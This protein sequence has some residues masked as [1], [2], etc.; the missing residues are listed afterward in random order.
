MIALGVTGS[1]AAYKAADLCRSFTKIGARVTVLMT[2]AAHEFIGSATMR[3]L[4]GRQVVTDLFAEGFPHIDIGKEAD[5]FVIAPATANT[6]AKLAAGVADCPITTTAAAAACPI[7]VC[8]AMN[9]T[10]WLSTANL[11]NIETLKALG[12]EII[13]PE[14]GDLA[15]G[16]EGWGRL[17]GLERIERAVVNRLASLRQLQGKKVMVTAGPT[18]EFLDPVRFIS[19]PSSGKT[20]YFVAEELA[21]RGADVVLVSGPTALSASKG[22]ELVSVATALDMDEQCRER[23]ADVDAVV[24]TAAVSDHR[25]ASVSSAKIEKSEFPTML[26]FE[27][28]PDILA[29]LGRTKRDQVLIGFAAETDD[30]EARGRRKLNKKQLDAIVCTK[31]G[32]G[33]GFGLDEIDAVIIDHNGAQVLGVIEKRQL[34]EKVVDVLAPMLL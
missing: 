4:S 7:I 17:A 13:G 32:V 6:I 31:V 5:V 26:E 30:I 25:F 28:N 10:M 24:M 12:Y 20:G 8:P 15:C 29:H 11:R 27:R 22:I 9:E 16:D 18:R 33:R 34:A 1:I 23:F 3:S 19:N 21:A 14:K 2:R